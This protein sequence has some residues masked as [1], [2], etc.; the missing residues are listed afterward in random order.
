MPERK[1]QQDPKLRKKR[2]QDHMKVL[3][4]LMDTNNL[5]NSATGRLESPQKLVIFYA[6][7]IA[8][9]RIW[10]IKTNCGKMKTGD[11]KLDADKN[12]KTSIIY[13]IEKE[14]AHPLGL[15]TSTLFKIAKF[16]YWGKKFLKICET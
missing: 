15:E 16:K 10:E 5:K 1:P 13:R 12:D 8:M 4:Y 7:Y 11:P 9:R 3:R 14:V 6:G 2:I